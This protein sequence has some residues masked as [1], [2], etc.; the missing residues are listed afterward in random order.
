MKTFEN[1]VAWEALVVASKTGSITRTALILDMEITRVSRLLAELEDAVGFPFFDKRRRPMRPT[2]ECIE[3]VN[4]LEPLIDGFRMLRAENAAPEETF[5]IRF[6]APAE[7]SQ[8]YLIGFLCTYSNDHP[9]TVFSLVPEVRPNQMHG[10]DVDAAVLN[11]MPDDDT[12]LVIRHFHSSSTVPLA[13]PEYLEKHGTPRTI[14]DLAHHTGLAYQSVNNPPITSLY[15]NGV[16]SPPLRWQKTHSCSN[17][18]LLKTFLLN[19]MGIATDLFLGHVVN[20]IQTGRIVPVLRGWERKPWHMCI[21]TRMEDELKTPRL[22]AFAEWFA[23]YAGNALR[24]ATRAGWRALNRN[25]KGKAE[26][27]REEKS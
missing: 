24:V 23:V 25:A 4:K 8:D 7:L 19:H 17:Q 26:P 12:G 15:R 16:A 18:L 3:L 1:L 9:N 6:A 20:E 27:G 13:T 5:R 11:H 22:R 21:A 10:T 2:P 14:A